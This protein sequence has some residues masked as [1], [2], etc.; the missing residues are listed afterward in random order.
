[1]TFAFKKIT[2]NFIIG[3]L[4]ISVIKIATVDC[5]IIGAEH[6]VP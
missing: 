5:S 1:M 4:R 6:T 3:F 2:V